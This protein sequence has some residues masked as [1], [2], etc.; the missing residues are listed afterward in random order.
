MYGFNIPRVRLQDK[1]YYCVSTGST[2]QHFSISPS[3][4][5]YREVIYLVLKVYKCSYPVGLMS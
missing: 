2:L 5:V 3:Y 4:P 1:I